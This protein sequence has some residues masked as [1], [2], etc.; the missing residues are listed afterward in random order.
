MQTKIKSQETVYTNKSRY[1]HYFSLNTL[2][3]AMS[4]YYELKMTLDDVEVTE[5]TTYTPATTPKT[6][7]TPLSPTGRRTP[8]RS[9]SST[10]STPMSRRTRM[11]SASS[12][13][14]MTSE[15]TE[16]VPVLPGGVSAKH[17]AVASE[18]LTTAEGVERQRIVIK[19]VRDSRPESKG[20]SGSEL[21][22]GLLTME[23]CLTFGG[24]FLE[25]I[26][27]TFVT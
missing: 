26:G 25:S 19:A 20:N 2:F 5:E 15:E 7:L 21:G 11:A 18:Q 4:R 12:G 13:H 16:T 22:P 23:V 10:D 9:T 17:E 1:F 8:L 27:D 3:F 14:E 6:P 24:H